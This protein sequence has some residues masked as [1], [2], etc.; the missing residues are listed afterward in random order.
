MPQKIDDFTIVLP[1]WTNMAECELK[2]YDGLDR[3][4]RMVERYKM[5]RLR[6][7]D[8]RTSCFDGRVCAGNTFLVSTQTALSGTYNWLPL[9]VKS[10]VPP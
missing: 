3:L 9:E 6:T 10:Q 8:P 7:V 1:E 2:L 5:N 4:W